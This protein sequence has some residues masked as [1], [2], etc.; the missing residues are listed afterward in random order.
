MKSD[1]LSRERV[2]TAISELFKETY[3]AVDDVE[4][5]LAPAQ[6]R[7][8]RYDLTGE[9]RVE[10]ESFPLA[11]TVKTSASRRVVAEL[12]QRSAIS[13]GGALHVIVVPYMWPGVAETAR[14][15]GL[16]Y[17]D[18]AGNAYLHHGSIHIDIRGREAPPPPDREVSL[19][20]PKASRVMRVLLHDPAAPVAQNRIG[21]MTGV[22]SGY[23][24]R[25]VSELAATGYVERTQAGVQVV[26]PGALLD[27]WTADYVRRR[28][29]WTSW[30]C[31]SDDV[32]AARLTSAVR[33]SG[34]SCAL[35]GLAAAGMLVPHSWG[36]AVQVYATEDALSVFEKMGAER[37]SGM[38]NLLVN[39]PPWDEGVF[40]NAR[41]VEKVCIVDPLQIYL[42]LWR[43]GDR[44]QETAEILRREHLSF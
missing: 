8:R 36:G 10:T 7:E 23:V 17:F 18:L 16:A 6:G 43:L 13:R 11:I 44:G 37:V 27:E 28:I 5:E 39:S 9:L 25:I 30:Q 15:L 19:F 29:S 4:I 12:A 31:L 1:S 38:G 26:D 21:E 42:D 3:R 20:S 41:T 22:S 40:L 14:E 24:S 32:Q 34:A 2:Q 33:E 35:S